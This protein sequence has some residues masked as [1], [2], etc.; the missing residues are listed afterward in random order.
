MIFRLTTSLIYFFICPYSSNPRRGW[1]NF[2]VS[3]QP[4]ACGSGCWHH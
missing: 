1:E 2:W 3:T 4:T